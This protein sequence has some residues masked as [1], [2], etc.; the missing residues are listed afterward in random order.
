MMN[1]VLLVG[2]TGYLGR[3]LSSC[4]EKIGFD[5]YITGIENSTHPKQFQILFNDQ[6]SYNCLIN[7]K[8][9]I[10]IILASKI[11]ALGINNLD[12]PDLKINTIDYAKFLEFLNNQ[13][14][15]KKLIYI[16]SMTVYGIQ[17]EL[18]VQEYGNIGPVN[19]YGLSK[20][21]AEN[22][23]SFFCLKNNI[24]GVI[25]RL[26]GIYG[27]NRRSGFIYSTTKKLLNN[28][29]VKIQTKGLIYWETIHID[30]LC[31]MIGSF[32]RN[33]SW[34]SL[35]DVFNFSYGEETDFYATA[36]FIQKQVGKAKI[37]I[38]E[39]EKGYTTLY[40]SNKKLL[41]YIPVNSHY[42]SS[43]KKYINAV[44]G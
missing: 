13:N 14:L 4:L 37:I 23:T 8:F 43:L 29:D 38:D 6:I 28:E 36:D 3:H 9:E 11:S 27:G 7:Q 40:L 20:Y 16:S 1:K 25:F 41:D 2:G 39:N 12:H 26:P 34:Q 35:I 18:P 32:I 10:V 44:K 19:T 24:F 33:Y 5:I 17:N 21:L 31:A 42:Y 15:T 22:I 30:D